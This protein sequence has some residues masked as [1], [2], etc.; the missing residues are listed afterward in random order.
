MNRRGV[1]SGHDATVVFD[2][3]EEVPVVKGRVSA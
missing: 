2:A 1:G 3:E